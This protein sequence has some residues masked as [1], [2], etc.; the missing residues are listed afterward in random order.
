[1]NIIIEANTEMVIQASED[2]E[3][4]IIDARNSDAYIGWSIDNVCRG[5]H[6]E[7][8]ALF[9]GA[10]MDSFWEKN[11]EDLRDRLAFQLDSQ[12]ITHE[13]NLIVYDENGQDA[14][15][16]CDYLYQQGYQNIFYYDLNQ[17]EGELVKYPH[18][19]LLAPVWWVKRLIDGEQ[20]AHY[21]GQGYKIFEISWKAPSRQYLAAHIP[22]A[23]HIDSDEFEK[24]PEWI[25]KS[26]NELL[27]FAAMN[28]ITADTTVIIY[29]NNELGASAK[30]SAVLRYMGVKRVMCLNGTLKNWI[31]AG[32]PTESGC[33]E[34]SPCELQLDQFHFDRTQMVDIDEAKQMLR[35]P[36][37]G[38]VIDTR[39]W[40]HY[41]GADS[42]YD[43]VDLAGR[44]PGT[45]WCFY[46]HFFAN[47]DDTMG[48]V[49]VMRRVWKSAGIDYRKRMA[50]FCG[51]ASWGAAV[52][53]LYG[54]VAGIEN[55]TIYE[56][57]WG[58][59]QLDPNNPYETGIPDGLEDYDPQKYRVGF[60]SGKKGCRSFFDE[61]IILL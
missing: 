42:G 43:Y 26:D 17:W 32:Y 37:L 1:M 16:V 11:I 6:I 52:V 4:K 50:F 61:G 48:D 10:W 47:P 45:V 60:S 24:P 55:A 53:K 23:V 20:V 56:G 2:P 15:Q 36:S 58:Q 7:G 29:G 25:R 46:P 14:S 21:T 22:G 51:S 18:Y 34:K 39:R 19:E 35:H 12:Q 44:I 27:Q 5:G 30:L 57:G 13:K 38:T 9:S 40:E 28:G 31:Y 41:I 8:A 49:N 33:P 59:W 3:W 54:N